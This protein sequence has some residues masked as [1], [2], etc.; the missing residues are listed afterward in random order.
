MTEIGVPFSRL[1]RLSAL[2]IQVTVTS[3]TLPRLHENLA[4]GLPCI[5]PIETR[6]LPYWR[7]VTSSHAVVMCGMDRRHVHLLDPGFAIGP[8][9]VSHDDFGL[10]WLER[11]EVYATMAA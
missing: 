5:V 6:E 11:D 10:A 2:G 3:G 1:L 8:F 9:L 4:S 7:G